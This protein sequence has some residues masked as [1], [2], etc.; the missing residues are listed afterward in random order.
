VALVTQVRAQRDDVRDLSKS[1]EMQLWVLVRVRSV[2]N[3]HSCAPQVAILS[4]PVVRL[5]LIG[6]L[7]S[8]HVP[9]VTREL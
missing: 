6:K 2:P 5:H 8:V 9:I 3:V 7:Q 1:E 4:F